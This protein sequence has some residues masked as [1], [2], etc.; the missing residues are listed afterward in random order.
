V[1]GI[2][3]GLGGAA[4][5]SPILLSFPLAVFGLL[6]LI[7]AFRQRGSTGLAWS[8]ARFGW[9]LLAQPVI[10]GA[11]FVLANPY[12]W[13]NP[14]GRTYAQFDF[15]RS[16]MDG[17][18]SAWPIAGVNGPLQ[19]LERTGRRF[20]MDYSTSLRIQHWIQDTATVSF[21]AISLDTVLMAAGLVVLLAIVVRRG[22]WSPHALVAYLMAAQCGVVIAGMGVDF[23]RYFLPLLVVASIC[24]GVGIGEGIS[25]MRGG[26]THAARPRPT[27]SR[28]GVLRGA[29]QVAV[30]S[31][32]HGDRN[33]RG[34]PTLAWDSWT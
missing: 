16:E 6:W 18:S 8:N 10:A 5:L 19:A 25:W 29:G 34:S 27:S 20:N 14:I 15:R 31:G 12:L 11:A 2:L 32:G 24:L 21:K 26:A 23:Y 13:P 28:P 17:Q 4:K 30:Q 9:L 1:L 3:L 33:R 7:V 22:L